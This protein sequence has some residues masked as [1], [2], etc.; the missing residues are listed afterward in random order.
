MLSGHILSVLFY[1]CFFVNRIMARF[2]PELLL[3]FMLVYQV[4]IMKFMFFFFSSPYDLHVFPFP[5][6]TPIFGYLILPQNNVQPP[7]PKSWAVQTMVFK[8]ATLSCNFLHSQVE[9]RILLLVAWGLR[10]N[11]QQDLQNLNRLL[12]SWPWIICLIIFC[13]S[14]F[15]LLKQHDVNKHT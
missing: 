10:Y 9:L 6:Y 4:F 11:L 5:S 12:Q 7:P 8:N 2:W 13:V 15:P 14:T 3:T 1:V